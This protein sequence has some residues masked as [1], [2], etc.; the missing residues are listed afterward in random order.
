M[1]IFCLGIGIQWIKQRRVLIQPGKDMTIEK[2]KKKNKL[3]EGE[4]IT[5]R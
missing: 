1:P 2:Q 4:G 5:R 3:E